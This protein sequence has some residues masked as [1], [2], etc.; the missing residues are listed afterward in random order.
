MSAIARILAQVIVVSCFLSTSSLA[1]WQAVDE[2]VA[3][4]RAQLNNPNVAMHVRSE[5]LADLLRARAELIESEASHQ[6]SLFWRTAQAEDALVE[7]MSINGLELVVRHEL[8]RPVQNELFDRYVKIAMEETNAIEQSLP[9][10]IASAPAGS[11]RLARLE[12]LRDSRLP[13]LRGMALVLAGERKLVSDPESAIRQG[14]GLL[15]RSL[16]MLRGGDAVSV[17]LQLALAKLS[18]GETETP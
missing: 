8:S 2:Q 11:G 16:A 3:Q 5:I 1:T 14:I 12:A 10:A 9:A 4:L 17:S 7:G 6:D 13:M 18:L 15:T